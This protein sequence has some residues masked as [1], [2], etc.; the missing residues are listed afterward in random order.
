MSTGADIKLPAPPE[1][2]LVTIV[3]HVDHG[4]TSLADNLITANGII[5]EKMSGSLRYLDSTEEERRRGITMH[6]SAIGLRHEYKEKLMVVHLI[7]SPGH[8]DFCQEVTSSLMACDGAIVVID[9]VEG[10]G[11]RSHAVLR[12][13]YS[14][15]LVP[16]LVINK[17]DRLCTELHLSKVE[18]YVKLRILLESINAACASIIN[19][20][21]SDENMDGTAKDFISTRE[22]HEFWDFDPAKG[23]VIFASALH[24]W[25]FSIPHLARSLFKSGVLP[26][27]PIALRKFLFGD[28]KYNSDKNKIFAWKPQNDD[29]S[30][31]PIFAEFALAPIWDIYNGIEDYTVSFNSSLSSSDV[32]STKQNRKL[33][34]TE[35]TPG[36]ASI[37]QALKCG[38]VSLPDYRIRS[39]DELQNIINSNS[40]SK[41][42]EGLQRAILR[43]FRTLSDT[44]MDSICENLPDPILATRKKS[45]GLKLNVDHPALS[46]DQR[47]HYDEIKRSIQACVPSKLTITIAYVF[48]FVAVARNDLSHHTIIS[49]FIEADS[50]T[51]LLGLTRVL[52][53]V[54]KSADVEYFLFGP[55]SSSD[56]VQTST[57]IDKK[58]V[59][60]FLIMGS[61][62]VAVKEVPAGHICAVS[63]LDDLRWRTLTLCN[64]EFGIPIRGLSLNSKPLVKVNVSTTTPSGIIKNINSLFC[65]K[66]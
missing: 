56:K 23:N 50:P 52:S 12:E 16:I 34:I 55:S 36:V 38:C 41:S 31:L 37:L 43:R 1:T 62:F 20:H 49:D 2:R 7:D 19:A 6:A 15:E 61:S 11:A 18:A 65:I 26:L 64:T 4:K 45:L 32:D 13:S 53:G 40:V 51:V 48:K 66:R 60:L 54:L 47:E 9:A 27:K 10:L 42:C 35:S 33:N 24:N 59:Q 57:T 5:N 14:N 63:N 22:Y 3:A 46:F 58:R 29:N 17:V 25:A 8:V 44:V 30:V 21:V 28:Y 39:F